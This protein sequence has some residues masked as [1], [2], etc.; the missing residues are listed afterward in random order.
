VAG[1]LNGVF[2][3]WINTS[4]AI[5]TIVVNVIA[6][7]DAVSA[8]GLPTDVT[9]T[10]DTASNLNLSAATI[11]DVDAS[12]AVFVGANFVRAADMGTMNVTGADFTDAVIDKYQ[13]AAMC[14]AGADGVN[15]ATGVSTR[16]SL[17]CDSL[18]RYE[19]FNAGA[20]VGAV[21][22]AKAKCLSGGCR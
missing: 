5:P 10:E 18:K 22:A 20:K 4:S 15:A 17:G 11:S 16:D 7:N 1:A 12:G 21:D 8:S 14:D 3:T 6:Q 9:V 19:G 2:S 13:V